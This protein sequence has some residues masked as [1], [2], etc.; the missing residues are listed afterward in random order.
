M[1]I[2]AMAAPPWASHGK[3]ERCHFWK[4]LRN[5]PRH[6]FLYIYAECSRLCPELSPKAL[7]EPQTEG[8]GRQSLD[9]VQDN[10][11]FLLCLILNHNFLPTERLVFALPT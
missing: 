11:L 5:K 6:G 4:L 3:G 9:S 1:L 10:P 8:E 2:N 7:L